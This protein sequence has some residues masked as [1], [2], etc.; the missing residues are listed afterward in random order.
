MNTAPTKTEEATEKAQ[1]DEELDFSF[2]DLPAAKA[3]K[4]RGVYKYGQLIDVR[5]P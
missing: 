1:E 3:R 2:T 4:P 5:E